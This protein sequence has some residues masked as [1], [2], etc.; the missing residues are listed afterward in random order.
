MFKL[1]FKKKKKIK[2]FPNSFKYKLVFLTQTFKKEKKK[3][4]RVAQ[5]IK[6]LSVMQEISVQFLDWEDP[7]EK[8]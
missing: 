3:I 2:A 1:D 4:S 7:L 6:N 5:L 8:G